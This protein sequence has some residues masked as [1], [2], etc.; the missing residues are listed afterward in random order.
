MNRIQHILLSLLLSL[1]AQTVAAQ[2]EIQLMTAPIDQLEDIPETINEQ[3]A[4]RFTRILTSAG[5]A[6]SANYR[7]FFITG[8][9]SHAFKDV[10][11][12]P[13]R[14]HVINTTLTIY[15]GD[16]VGQ[17][18][19]ETFS[20][21]LK[22]VGNTEE[23]AYISAL[24]GLNPGNNAFKSFIERGKRKILTY[25][26]NNYPTILRRAATA[27]QT[28]QYEE[29]LMILSTIP[30]CCVGFDQASNAML[31]V[32]QS[33]LDTEGQRLLA[34][35]R[36][37]WAADPTS[38]GAT[39]ACSYLTQINPSSKAFAQAQALVKDIQ[40]VTRA[41]Y[42]FETQTK[43]KDEISLQKAR[44]EAA[45]AIGVAFGRGPKANYT[46]RITFIR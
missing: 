6:A 46:S 10:L 43:Y 12:G 11:P 24:K 23:R 29:A 39:E 20:L 5:V 17:T 45:R 2:C 3:L 33:Y 30:E 25:Y 28:G 40:K 32:Y 13:P 4:T 1:T 44:I 16:I 18:V 26:D 21:D 37:A 31:R 35:G 38:G 41:D 19:Y 9:F 34:L 36:A 27:E 8:K 7:Q 42:V 22:G 15:I 14:Q